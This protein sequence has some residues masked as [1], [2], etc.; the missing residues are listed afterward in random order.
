VDGAE[1]YL[2]EPYIPRSSI[3]PWPYDEDQDGLY[4]HDS[5]GDGI[6]AQMRIEDEDGE[7]RASEKDPRVIV[8]R[9][10]NEVGGKYYAVFG[11]GLIKGWNGVEVKSAESK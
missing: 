6:I 4:P 10:P 2:T 7:W 9:K 3:C 5:D 1:L 8:R 11:E